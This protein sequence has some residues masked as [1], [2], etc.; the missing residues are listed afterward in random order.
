MESHNY[1]IRHDSLCS[2]AV[3][4]YCA[5]KNVARFAGPDAMDDAKRFVQSGDVA[6]AVSNLVDCA[7]E[8]STLPDLIEKA[9]DIASDLQEQ[10]YKIV[11]YADVI[12]SFVNN[13]QD[14]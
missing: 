12:E 1:D 13:A 9:R 7:D 4:V 11:A 3:E 5:G 8:L 14:M 2:G 6:I 10:L